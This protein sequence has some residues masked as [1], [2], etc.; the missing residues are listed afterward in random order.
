MYVPDTVLDPSLI[1][2]H[3]ILMTAPKDRYYYYS[4][5]ETSS[6]RWTNFNQDHMDKSWRQDLTPDLTDS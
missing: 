6:E 4:H 5:K 1:L 2:S 3:L